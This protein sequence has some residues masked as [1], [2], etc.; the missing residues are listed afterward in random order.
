MP[1][2]APPSCAEVTTSLVW[3]DSTEVKTFT[4]S[5]M[6]APARVPQE[7]MEE[8]FHHSEVSPPRLGMMKKETRYVSAIETNE[9]IQTSEVSGVSKFISLAL[10]KRALAMAPLRKY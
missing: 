7:I 8:S 10:L 5:G 4:S 9:V 3:R 1:R 2:D 6:I